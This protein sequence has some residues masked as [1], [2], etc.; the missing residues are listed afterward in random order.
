[1]RK[2]IYL[3]IMYS[4]IVLMG[5]EEASYRKSLSEIDELI[6]DY[7][8]QARL[9]LNRADSNENKAYYKLLDTKIAIRQ[10]F[11]TTIEYD[12]IN[13]CIR[14]L[15]ANQ[16]S[17]NLMWALYCKASMKLYGERDTASAKT[18]Y[19]R[20]GQMNGDR[21]TL[22]MANTYNQLCRIGELENYNRLQQLSRSLKDTLLLAHSYVYQALQEN[23]PGYA[24]KAF[25]LLEAKGDR[26][27]MH[28][29]CHEYVR[30][31]VDA[32]APDSVIMRYLPEATTPKTPVGYFT[33][34]RHL[35][36]HPHPEFAKEYIEK[37]GTSVIE[38]EK[39]KTFFFSS[40]TYAL[41][42][43]MYF[44]AMKEGNKS[45]A[46]SLLQ[47]MRSIENV[48]ESEE[49]YHNEK[50][51]GLMYEGGNARYRYLRNKTYVSYGI[52][53]VLLFLLLLA[54]WH[55]R[56]MKRAN[57]IISILTES[58]H[59]LKEVENPALSD[60]CDKLSHE[61]DNQLR[62]LKH[63]EADISAYKQQIEQLDNVSKGLV[64]YA[65]ILQNRN[66]SQIGRKG[67]LQFL[68]SYHLIDEH[69]S[70]R[71]SQFDLN[72][73]SQLFCVLYHLGKTDEEVM[74]IMQYSLANVRTRKSRIKADT[75]VD[76][77][78]NLI[79]NL[80]KK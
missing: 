12:Y 80:G 6:D 40:A 77:F 2:A 52:I 9:Y 67:I 50:E 72:P 55:I 29:L 42:A 15:E 38:Y 68:D 21:C 37:H 25:R 43:N 7:P 16:D 47:E 35:F 63:R 26:Q 62:R 24:D 17:I 28:R 20:I 30:A 44:V 34:S 58:V 8:A 71:L 22:V 78:E 75:E 18:L 46:D 19:Q 51:V 27:G 54:Y 65:Q 73:S 56:R 11:Y 36:N 10:G 45:L 57:R 79:T 14:E 49:N 31:L 69:F 4:I 3:Y 61:I 23:Q 76:S 41:M 70:Q 33:A 1:M 60:R 74:Q 13:S 53:A 39:E 59:H 66:I 32:D 48:F 5:C 64:I